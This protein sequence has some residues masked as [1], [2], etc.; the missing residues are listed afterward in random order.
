[1]RTCAPPT[2]A[3]RPASASTPTKPDTDG[4]GTCD[5]ID[6]CPD[7][8]PLTRTRGKLSRFTTPAGDDRVDVKTE[9]A[10]PA[11]PT[12][13]PVQDGI[14]LQLTNADGSPAFDALLPPGAWSKATRTGW[15]VN[16]F[17]TAFKFRSPT[18]RARITPVRRRPGHVA[19]SLKLVDQAIASATPPLG[20]RLLLA[21]DDATQGRCG[22]T[23]LASCAVG[24]GGATL[25]CK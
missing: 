6:P 24:K 15:T 2:S 11:S 23:E 4:D 10:V 17:G 13:D 5:L 3:T 16:A 1:M 9:V 14:V 18:A 21:P 20:V 8:A 7:G 22:E 12:I 25:I 19:V